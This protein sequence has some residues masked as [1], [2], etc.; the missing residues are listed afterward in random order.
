MGGLQPLELTAYDRLLQSRP[1]LGPD[2]RLLVVGINEQDIQNQGQFPLPDSTLVTLFKKLK[3]HQPRVIGLDM[4]RGDISVQPGRAQNAEADRLALVE[5]LKQSDRMIAI[6][7]LGNEA[8]QT[9]PPPPGVP[10]EQIG[11]NDVTVDSGRVLRRNLL[12][13][14]DYFP[15]FS[16]RVALRYLRDDGIEDQPSEADENVLQL[17]QTAFPPLKS[18]DG[19]YA[20]IDASNTYQVM[21]NYRSALNSVEQVSLTQVLE[22]KV[23]PQKIKDRIVLIGTTGANRGDLYVTPYN[24]G[25]NNQPIMPG[26][27]VHAQMVSQFLDAAYGQRPLIRSLSDPLEMAWI[28]AWSLIGGLLAWTVRRPLLL[29]IGTGLATGLLFILCRGLFLQSLWMP[30]V[31]PF[32]ALLG[33]GGSVVSYRAQQAQRQQKMVMR[34]LGQSSSPEIAETLWQ[35]RDEL[36]EGGKLLG[37]ELTATLLFTDLKGFSTISEKLSPDKLLNWLNEYFE[38]MTELVVDHQ[39]VINK[40]TGDGLIAVFGVPLPRENQDEIAK[41]AERAVACSLKMGERLDDLNQRW[42]TQGLPEVQMRAGIFTGS[43]VVGSLG[44]KSRLEYG[45]IGDSVNIASRL[46]SV[47][48]DRQPSPCRVLIAQETLDYLQGNYEV[49]A[50]GALT[51]KGKAEQVEVYRVLEATE[52]ALE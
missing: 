17:G 30:V 15:S 38:V 26:V 42:Q 21:L 9:V 33:A 4:W 11:F 43:V 44:S 29:I 24:S 32:L 7:F 28:L 13:V 20:N 10:E 48:K 37:Q 12:Y 5:Q 46:E 47:D 51:L 3:L 40:F 16:L 41:D 6:T 34:L 50:W 31:P 8:E 52:H 49:E 1:D 19:G 25:A 23:D 45:V 39:G 27:V 18:D 35:R 14:D 36:L 2:S 22:G